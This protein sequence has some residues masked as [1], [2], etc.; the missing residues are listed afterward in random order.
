MNDLRDIQLKLYLALRDVEE[1]LDR[2]LRL[3]RE[4]MDAPHEPRRVDEKD[5]ENVDAKRIEK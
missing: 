5:V 1:P 4:L 3:W 2:V